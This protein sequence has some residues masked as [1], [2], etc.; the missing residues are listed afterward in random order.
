MGTV[1]ESGRGKAVVMGIGLKTEIGKIARSI[2]ILEEEKTPYQKKIAHFSKIVAIVVGIL[3]LMIFVGG[4][5]SGRDVLEM[6]VT[7]IAVAVA[8]IPEGLPVA[9][10]VILAIGMERILKKKGLV[11]KLVA[12]EVLGSTS[13]ICTD[14][15]GTL[16]LAK[17]QVTDIFD[18]GHGVSH[19]LA[20]KAGMFCSEAFVE[21]I[22]DPTHK[23]II[24]GRPTEKAVLL[25]ALQAGLRK[26]DLEKK[27]PQLDILGFDA[28]Y[29]FSAALH[30]FN[31]EKDI[32]Y[33]LG[34]PEIV[35]DKS[36][37]VETKNGNKRISNKQKLV[38]KFEKLNKQGLRLVA[39]GYRK[40][41]KDSLFN[42]LE[43]QKKITELTEKQKKA[44]YEKYLNEMVFIA[45][46]AIK[47]PLRSD[48]K[49]AI[50]V[51]KEAGIKPIIVTG[52]H[53]LTAMAIAKELDIPCSKKNVIT[54][55][56][57]EELSDKAF[58]KRLKDISIYARMEP[59][60]KLRIIKAWQKK[61]QVVAMT[62]D[63][64]NDAP[65]LKRADIGLAL[66]SGTDV[67]KEASDLILLTDNFS[68]IVTAIKQGRT[69]IDNIRKVITLLF[70]NAFGEM[71]LI[72][73]SLLVGWPL[74]ILPAQILW[75]NLIEDSLPAISLG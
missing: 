1:V 8:A 10:T 52:D 40:I 49:H 23:W 24:R 62:G 26:Q 16:T 53:V 71:V 31:K 51:C 67:A 43:E 46:I 20:L 38:K 68:I 65:A 74:P 35:L 33:I 66:G 73:A 29:K 2:S 37:Y 11:R 61:G 58:E 56:E 6:F 36:L 18:D 60:Q 28:D 75:V 3:S 25:A 70:S 13:V 22:D 39:V 21:N 59:Q 27:E 45:F 32:L 55:F 48:V 44:F 4:V 34:A 9:I 57:F 47:D 17:M 72:G 19:E 54:N 69:I 12:S 42:D 41:K 64:V 14:K 15:T 50:K 7:A 63:G 30:K 5:I